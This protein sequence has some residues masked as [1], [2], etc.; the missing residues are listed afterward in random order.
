MLPQVLL[1]RITP[2]GNAAGE[3]SRLCALS[4][5]EFE[6]A[7]K[8]A[9]GTEFLELASMPD[10]QDLYVDALEFGEEEE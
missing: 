5:A 1:D 10:F 6:Y 2:I 9:S 7:K 4:R 3:G 8:L